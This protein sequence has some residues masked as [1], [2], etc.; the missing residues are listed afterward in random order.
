MAEQGGER[1]KQSVMTVVD[2]R[3]DVEGAFNTALPPSPYPGLRPFQKAEWPIFFGR[4]PMTDAL[5]T[6]LLER[7]LAVVHGN[8][9]SG[10]SSLVRAGIQ[11]HIEQQLARCGLRWRTCATR[12][13]SQPLQNLTDA[14]GGICADWD[15]QQLK[16]RRALNQGRQS[17]A[18]L[19]QLLGLSAAN[20]LC[21]V[22]DQFEE[23]F[24]FAREVSRDKSSLLTDFVV[25][26]EKIHLMGSTYLSP[27]ARNSSVNAPGS[28]ASPRRS[29]AR[30]I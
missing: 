24:R 4:E 11:A 30:N 5:I 7:R 6:Q 29:T 3:T 18:T 13:G 28:P 1:P 19:A 10:K 12:P 25:G 8:S 22:L 21:I 17:S 23:L 15:S 20:R 2:D 16:I 9:G 27:C 26:F 14:L